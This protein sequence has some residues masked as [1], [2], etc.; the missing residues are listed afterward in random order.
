[1]FNMTEQQWMNVTVIVAIVLTVP[2]LWRIERLLVLIADK[3]DAL[4]DRVD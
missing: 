4:R 3:L 1:M 2:T